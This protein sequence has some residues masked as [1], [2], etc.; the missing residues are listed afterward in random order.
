MPEPPSLLR[1]LRYLVHDTYRDFI[2]A[3][4]LA[5]RVRNGAISPEQF[6]KEIDERFPP[7]GDEKH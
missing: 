1:A 3:L 4:R 6:E 7:I 5:R 2:D